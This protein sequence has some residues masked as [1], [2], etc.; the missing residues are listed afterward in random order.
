MKPIDLIP[1]LIHDEQPFILLKGYYKLQESIYELILAKMRGVTHM[2]VGHTQAFYELITWHTRNKENETMKMTAIEFREAIRCNHLILL[3][4]EED[5]SGEIW[6]V[7]EKYK[8]IVKAYRKA[9]GEDKEKKIKNLKGVYSHCPSPENAAKLR[10]A[11]E[12][13]KKFYNK[14][15]EKHNII[16]Y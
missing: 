9:G 13:Y 5:N 16:E 14:F 12:H 6:G 11:K 1:L 10:K 8:K 3:H 2:E 4:R 7:N 15:L